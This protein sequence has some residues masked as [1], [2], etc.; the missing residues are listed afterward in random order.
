MH[1]AAVRRGGHM[2]VPADI[3][4]GQQK[5]TAQP[6]E[7]AGTWMCPLTFLQDSKNARRSRPKGRAH[8]CAR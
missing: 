6:S 5:C 4:A 8:G 3:F 1:G 7:G 2:D